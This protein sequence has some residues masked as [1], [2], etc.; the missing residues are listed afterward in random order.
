[1]RKWFRYYLPPLLWVALI[2]TFSTSSFSGK[3]TESYLDRILTFLWPGGYH[4]HI[5]ILD[6]LIRKTAHIVE[7]AVLAALWLKALIKGSGFNYGKAVLVTTLVSL[8]CAAADEYHQSY[9]P[10]RTSSVADVALD[11]AAALLY[12][13]IINIGIKKRRLRAA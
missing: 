4:G 11:L 10:D 12:L 6:H 13:S 9:L 3:V 7:Y 2:F 1:M 8:F 5:E